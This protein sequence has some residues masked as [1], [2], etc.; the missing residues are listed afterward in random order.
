LLLEPL[1]Q[2]LTAQL[3]AVGLDLIVFGV[4]LLAVI[5]LLP[6]GIIPTLRK[7]WAKRIATRTMA[8]PAI[9]NRRTEDA[10]PSVSRQ[11]GKG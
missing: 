7:L 1:Q 11:G 4:T 5:L 10:I 9:K 2:Y 8:S 3:G 6:E